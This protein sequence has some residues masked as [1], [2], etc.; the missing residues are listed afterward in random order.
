MKRL[1]LLLIAPALASVLLASPRAYAQDTDNSSVAANLAATAN[2]ARNGVGSIPSFAVPVIQ[3][4]SVPPLPAPPVPSGV[5]DILKGRFPLSI[6]YEDLGAGW[7]VFDINGTYFSRGETVFVSGTEYVVAY[8]FAYLDIAKLSP[9]DYALYASRNLFR[10]GAGIRFRLSL[11]PASTVQSQFTNG[12]VGLH[13]FSPEDYKTAAQ[14]PTSE[15]FNQ[16]LALVYLRKI[17]EAFTGYSG[18]NLNVLPPLESAF[19]ARQGLEEFAEN[20]AIFT[21]PG[22]ERPFAFNPLFSGRKRAHLKGKGYLILAYEAE[23]APDGSHAVL[24]LGGKVSR[25]SEKQWNKLA[26]ASQ[27]G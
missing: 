14:L 7:R 16:N 5:G 15:A 26:G 24:T 8:K 6:G 23:A 27:L 12:E 18:A 22:T 2:A 17:G 19:V 13:S 25:L 3:I 20:P 11:L 1:P 21:Q 9:R 4:P 10:T